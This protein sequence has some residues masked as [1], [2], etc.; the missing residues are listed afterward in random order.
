MLIFHNQT[1]TLIKAIHFITIIYFNKY[2][3][4]PSKNNVLITVDTNFNSTNSIV[5]ASAS[6]FL[7][8]NFCLQQFGT[9]IKYSKYGNKF[10]GRFQVSGHR[11]SV[12]FKSIL[13]YQRGKIDVSILDDQLHLSYESI[14]MCSGIFGSH[15]KR[16]K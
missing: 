5:P 15:Q 7:I 3:G 2:L 10:S 13:I 11:K 9:K 14:Y 4:I 1:S 12:R 16:I 8:C 6:S